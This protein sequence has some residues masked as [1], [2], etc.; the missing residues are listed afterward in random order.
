MSESNLDNDPKPANHGQDITVDPATYAM[1]IK[2]INAHELSFLRKVV[3]RMST[4]FVVS[5][6]LGGLLLAAFVAV[7]TQSIDRQYFAYD[8]R[9]GAIVELIPQ[10]RPNKTSNA[11]LSWTMDCVE[12]A[13][14]YDVVN[15]RKQLMDAS[16]CFTV[17]GWNAFTKALESSGNL[18]EVKQKKMIAS[19]V[20]NGAAIIQKEGVNPETG[21]YTYIVRFPLK[22]TYQGE[23]RMPTQNM[24]ITAMVERVDSAVSPDGIG[25]SQIIGE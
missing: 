14:S 7:K 12:R 20:R 16:S 11:L 5:L 19:G 21:R 9:T 4:A 25:I 8:S 15:Y 18:E 24:V 2:L 17:D 6:I 23:G 10:D 22:V 3:M 13:Y 1:L